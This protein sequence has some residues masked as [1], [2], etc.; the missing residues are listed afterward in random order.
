MENALVRS[1]A[2]SFPSK[3]LLFL[4]FSDSRVDASLFVFRF[5]LAGVINCCWCRCYS[6]QALFIAAGE[7]V[8]HRRWLVKVNEAVYCLYYSLIAAGAT[9]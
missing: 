1:T 4:F 2:I 7:A 8:M 9:L 5:F 6:V 3:L